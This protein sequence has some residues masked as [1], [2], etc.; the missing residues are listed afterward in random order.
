MFATRT[1]SQNLS[2]NSQMLLERLTPARW[3]EINQACMREDEADVQHTLMELHNSYKKG[4]DTAP[5]GDKIT[6]TMIRNLGPT[7]EVA[8]LR[9]INRTHTERQRPRAWNLQDTQP[10]PKPKDPQNPRPIALTSCLGKTAEKMVLERLKHRVG[11]LHPHLY[12]YQ[13]GVGTTECI[14]DV[15]NC[16]NNKP[17]LVAFL[18]FEKAFELANPAA[19]LIS[20]VRK[21]QGDKGTHPGQKQKL[22]DEQTGQSQISRYSLDLQRL[23]E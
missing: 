8:L 9:L 15:L 17:D 13:E 18:D 4:K 23:G 21:G 12:A 14:T 22:P 11:P 6:Y 1:S 3:L 2:A 20:L 7:G 10:I 5:G 19:I 16:I